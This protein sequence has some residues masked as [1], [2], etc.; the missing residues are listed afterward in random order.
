MGIARNRAYAIIVYHRVVSDDDPRRSLNQA[1]KIKISEFT[2]QMDYLRDACV[3][4][5]LEWMV[6]R[7]ARDVAPD[8]FYVSVT[9]D[10]G[11]A[12]NLTHAFPVLAS[13]QIPATIFITTGFIEGSIPEPW[14]DDL[15]ER[16]S[17]RQ[18]THFIELTDGKGC[19][20]DL[21][22]LTEKAALLTDVARTITSA[23]ELLPDILSRIDDQLPAESISAGRGRFLSWEQLA[24]W[25]RDELVAVAPHTVTHPFM[26]ESNR[27][28][29]SEAVASRTAL[30]ERL[31]GCLNMFAYPYGLDG[32][33]SKTATDFLRESGFD[34]AFTVAFRYPHKDNN[35]LTLPRIPISGNDGFEGFL[36]KL[37][38]AGAYDASL[39]LKQRFVK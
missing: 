18:G 2:Q 22:D 4:V 12:D 25:R 28:Y 31:G 20:Y 9:F 17:Q 39:R 21:S 23:P 8:K 38:S 27:K 16:V 37:R 30:R 36:N 15:E 6:G 7:L 26:V 34:A 3:P 24:Q 32:A 19:A 1:V 35:L 5:P 14:W 11:Y 10:D 13:R 29:F 33:Y